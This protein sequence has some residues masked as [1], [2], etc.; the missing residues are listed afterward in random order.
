MRG[1]RSTFVQT[2]ADP[3]IAS[4]ASATNPDGTD[5]TLPVSGT[6][7]TTP[8]APGAPVGQQVTADN[9][10]V[11]FAS[12]ACKRITVQNRSED[13]AGVAQ[14]NDVL[15][16]I[17]GVNTVQLMPAMSAAFAVDNADR[18]TLKTFAGTELCVAIIEP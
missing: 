13:D 16:V 3:A 12:Q 8:A 17:G 15:V 11:A 9:V 14:A 5:Y 4:M 18:V 6:V 2:G 10:G 7:N 1:D